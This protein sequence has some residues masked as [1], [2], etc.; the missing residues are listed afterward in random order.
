LGTNPKT[1]LIA[2]PIKEML[3][4]REALGGNS[5]K[6]SFA[7]LVLKLRGTGLQEGTKV[8][9]VFFSGILPVGANG[10]PSLAQTIL[11]CVAGL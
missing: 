2:G 4:E 11:V 6:V 10:L 7:L 8:V 9:T 5:G 1:P 3:V